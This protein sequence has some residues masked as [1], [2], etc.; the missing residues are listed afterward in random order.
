MGCFGR[1]MVADGL[2]RAGPVSFTF[3]PC[4]LVHKMDKKVDSFKPVFLAK[5]FASST[6]VA[7][8]QKYCNCLYKERVGGKL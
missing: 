3:L 1:D 5:V 6:G 2:R 7:V 8:G 4:A